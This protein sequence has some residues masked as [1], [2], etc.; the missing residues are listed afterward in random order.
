MYGCDGC[1]SSVGLACLVLTVTFEHLEAGRNDGI[2][3]SES[4]RFFCGDFISEIRGGL[5]VIS[6]SM[7]IVV[8]RFGH[9]VLIRTVLL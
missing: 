7:A 1:V 6:V 4:E 5:S 2:S 8:I 3:S 9:R